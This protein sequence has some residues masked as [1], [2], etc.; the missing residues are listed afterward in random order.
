MLRRL[1]KLALSFGADL[2]DRLARMARSGAATSSCGVVLYYHA[3]PQA[4]QGA[5]ARQMQRLRRWAQFWALEAP[6]PRASRWVGISFDDAYE[7]VWEN[8]VP[9]LQQ[10][11]IPF[12]IFVPTGSLG[13]RPG[14]V[15]SE[16]HPFWQEKVMA[17]ERIRE[18][19]ALPSVTLGSHTVSHP[20]LTRLSKAEAERELKDSKRALEDLT[21]RPVE[22]LSFPHGDWNA[23]LVDVA[24]AAGYRRLFGIEPVRVEGTTLPPVVGR[25]A[26]EP[27]DTMLEFLLKLK[28]CYRWAAR[29]HPGC[30]VT[31]Q[32]NP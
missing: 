2:R 14:W 7:S 22:L 18:L 25:V 30:R 28:G 8:A 6:L 1:V 17:A 9:E 13:R 21:G 31:V 12:T 4:Q 27:S 24:R 5:F 32:R 10:L 3:V 29:S 26:V 19:A 15:H 20:R 23:R 11:A 16:R